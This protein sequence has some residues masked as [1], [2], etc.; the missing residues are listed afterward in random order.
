MEAELD[1]L[2]RGIDVPA[3]KTEVIIQRP[4]GHQHFGTKAVRQLGRSPL[5][6]LRIVQQIKRSLAGH[7]VAHP[8]DR[9]GDHATTVILE[10]CQAASVS[11][12]VGQLNRPLNVGWMQTPGSRSIKDRSACSLYPRA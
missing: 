1:V 3:V 5:C 4:L 10:E 9:C 12:S 11:N 2:L 7:G 8:R 6:E